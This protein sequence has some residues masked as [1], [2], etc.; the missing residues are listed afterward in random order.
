MFKVR[1][2]RI[3]VLLER[4]NI[5]FKVRHVRIFGLLE[6]NNNLAAF[7]VHHVSILVF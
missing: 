4:K 1:H 7:K 3:F 6:K 2:V 5:L